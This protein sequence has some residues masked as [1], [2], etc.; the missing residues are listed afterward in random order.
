MPY[1]QLGRRPTDR[2]RYANTITLPVRVVP[3]H[4]LVADHLSKVPAW[5]L[6]QNMTYGTCGPVSVANHAVMTWKYLLGQNITV[7]DAAVFD[8]YRRSGNPNFDPATGADDDGVDMT[9]MLS[10]LVKG[11]IE[12]TMPDG[13]KRVEKPLCFARATANATDGDGIRA[14]RAYTSIFG[15]LLFALDLQEAQ[16]W[17]TDAGLWA[18]MQSEE[19][20]GHATM[21]GKYTSDTDP[22]HADESLVTWAQVVGT[23]DAFLN[24]QLA[25]V[26]VIVWRPLWDTPAFQA[27][28]D[29]TRLAEDYTAATGR[30]FPMPIPTPTPPPP[31]VPTDPDVA[32]WTLLKPWAT[33]R[34]WGPN[35]KAADTVRAWA[36]LK[37]FS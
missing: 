23:T 19:W 11:G 30:P 15:G 34:R 35:R 10:A 24:Q 31:P 29:K 1:G 33:G 3:D 32:L 28:V 6:G 8:L 18:Y 17:Q 12:L 26:Y 9:V 22:N 14:I 13:S 27:G 37:G 2:T 5:V 16:Q 4:P 7:S 36:R 25:E 21:A 20:G